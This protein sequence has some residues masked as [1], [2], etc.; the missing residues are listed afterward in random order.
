MICYKCGN[1]FESDK[2][3]TGRGS[4]QKK[5][6]QACKKLAFMEKMSSYKADFS[7]YQFCVLCNKPQDPVLD[8]YLK[9]GIVYY[10]GKCK[11]CYNLNAREYRKNNPEKCQAKVKAWQ[12]KNHERHAAYRE[13]YCAKLKEI[14]STPEGQEKARAKDRSYTARASNSYIGHLIRNQYGSGIIIP[15]EYVEI[16]R[17][18]LLVKRMVRDKLKDE[19]VLERYCPRC[20]E[21]KPHTDYHKSPKTGKL[22]AYCKLCYSIVNKRYAL[23][24]KINETRRESSGSNPEDS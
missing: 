12:D 4:G 24:R 10:R 19:E 6:C 9:Y 15:K 2:P 1:T 18:A 13:Q 5:Q 7:K 8:A 17:Q 21:V 22:R 14:R 16:K 3:L 23:E 20:G 11:A